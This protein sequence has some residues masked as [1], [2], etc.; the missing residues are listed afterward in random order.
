MSYQRR[1]SSI[2]ESVTVVEVFRNLHTGTWSAQAVTGP[3]GMKGKIVAHPT[4][5]ILADAKFKVREL[6]RLKVLASCNKNVHARVRGTPVLG[7]EG[8]P[9]DLIAN[10]GYNPYLY[11]SFVIMANNQPIKRAAWVEF[12]EEVGGKPVPLIAG[13]YP[14][15][16]YLLSEPKLP[17]DPRKLARM[18]W[19]RQ[20][21]RDRKRLAAEGKEVPLANPSRGRAFSSWWNG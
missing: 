10:V 2:P 1:A 20:S 4:R 7:V 19:C 11:D 15:D 18:A 12:N 9:S 14:E 17:V 3:A 6:D 13:L 16:A 5:A 21:S 8:W